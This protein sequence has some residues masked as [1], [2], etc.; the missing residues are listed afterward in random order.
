MTPPDNWKELITYN[1]E[2]GD[3]VWSYPVGSGRGAI[4]C[5]HAVDD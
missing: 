3:F 4:D 2:T 1:P 5:L